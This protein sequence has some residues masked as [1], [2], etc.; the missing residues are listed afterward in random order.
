MVKTVNVGFRKAASVGV[1]RERSV[2]RGESP[3]LDEGPA[4]TTFTKA[5]V[6]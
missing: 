4:F 3:A 2:L 1:G 6:L 5:V